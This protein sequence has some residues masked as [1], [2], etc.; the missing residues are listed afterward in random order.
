MVDTLDISPFHSDFEDV[1]VTWLHESIACNAS[2]TAL[3]LI[4][5]HNKGMKESILRSTVDDD[6][7][8]HASPLDVAIMANHG[9]TPF[10]VDVIL[11]GIPGGYK[12]LATPYDVLLSR[13]GK[14]GEVTCEDPT[15]FVMQ[16]VKDNIVAKT[17]SLNQSFKE[18]TQDSLI[19]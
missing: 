5:S 11:R 2:N 14:L 4:K 3:Y 10:Y 15:W 8:E 18:I 9:N 6:C 12:L 1:Y 13:I 16:C 7:V 19:D 17:Y